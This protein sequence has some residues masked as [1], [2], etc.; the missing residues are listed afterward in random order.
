MVVFKDTVTIDVAARVGEVRQSRALTVADLARKIEIPE[1]TL[2]R[3]LRVNNPRLSNV[4]DMAELLKVQVAFLVSEG[5]DSMLGKTLCN[6]ATNLDFG[7]IVGLEP[8][9][10]QGKPNVAARIAMFLKLKGLSKSKLSKRIDVSPNWWP[11][12]LKQNNPSMKTLARLAY[13]LE[14]SP[15]DLVLPVSNDEYGQVMIPNRGF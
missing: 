6:D 8:G 13:A 10:I 1:S 9:V 3:F 4:Y 2:R 5:V 15:V 14:V 12:T 11:P 7:E